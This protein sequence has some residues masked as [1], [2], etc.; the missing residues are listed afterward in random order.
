MLRDANTILRDKLDRLVVQFK[1]ANPN[2]YQEYYATRVVVDARGGNSLN[3]DVQPVN[4]SPAPP[5][6]PVNA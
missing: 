2:F 1:A 3:A 4:P 5:P 6:T